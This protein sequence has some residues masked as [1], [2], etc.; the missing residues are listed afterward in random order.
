MDCDLPMVMY[1]LS[2][3]PFDLASGANREVFEEYPVLV[4]PFA[5]TAYNSAIE[6][7]R[8]VMMETD[9]SRVTSFM[10]RR[11]VPYLEMTAR[12]P[13]DVLANGGYP[14]HVHV[15]VTV[16]GTMTVEGVTNA[17]ETAGLTQDVDYKRVWGV[18]S[19]TRASYSRII[20]E[21]LLEQ[22][23]EIRLR[24]ISLSTADV[25]LKAYVL[26][27]WCQIAIGNEIAGY[28]GSKRKPLLVGRSLSGAI[29]PG[30]MTDA[31]DCV[32]EKA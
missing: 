10:L 12:F 29:N 11:D 22:D 21:V 4:T 13:K 20:V 16:K 27:R 19:G 28:M 14:K 7:T 18:K 25:F 2:K 15:F 1:T 3:F 26:C 9:S 17:L 6:S 31:P 24:L 23:A 30:I 8:I 5:I 32:C